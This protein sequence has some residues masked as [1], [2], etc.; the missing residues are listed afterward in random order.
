MLLTVFYFFLRKPG[1]L[2]LLYKHEIHWYSKTFSQKPRRGALLCLNNAFSYSG[3][4]NLL[5]PIKTVK[6]AVMMM[7][8]PHGISDPSFSDPSSLLTSE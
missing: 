7:N 6:I 2:V 8:P 3:F 5:K 4:N 1:V